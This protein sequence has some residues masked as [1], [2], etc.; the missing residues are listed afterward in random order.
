M[1]GGRLVYRLAQERSSAG[2]AAVSKTAGRGFESCRSCQRTPL[3]V[4]F[5][6]K[7]LVALRE[8]PVVQA[9]VSSH[10]HTRAVPEN[11]LR[12]GSQWPHHRE[13]QPGAR[14][15]IAIRACPGRG[16]LCLGCGERT[17]RGES[18]MRLTL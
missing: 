17:C 16:E 3:F 18:L 9:E 15:G 6:P 4:P 8:V 14:A 12:F 11:W 13:T 5:P 1:T 7:R 10:K 2:R